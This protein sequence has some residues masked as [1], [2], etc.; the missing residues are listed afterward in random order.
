MIIFFSL[1]GKKKGLI[2][3]SQHAKVRSLVLVSQPSLMCMGEH[4][5]L[6]APAAVTFMASL[7]CLS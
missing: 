6:S 1:K 3:R 4:W 2:L 5:V 7:H